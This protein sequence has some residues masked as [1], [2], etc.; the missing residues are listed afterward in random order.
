MSVE[1][2]VALEN[3]RRLVTEYSPL[4]DLS[5]EAQTRFSFVDRL[6]QE[7]LGWQNDEVKVETY[8]DGDRTDYE[9]GT[10]R[11]LII[12]AKRSSAPLKLPP[13]STRNPNRAR[14]DSIIAYS[15]VTAEAIKQ[16]QE[17]C[18]KRGVELAVLSNAQQLIIF[19]AIRTDGLAPSSGQAFVFDGYG[20]Q[21]K[22]F[23]VVFDL[24]SSDGVHEKRYQELLGG[25]AN[26]TLPTKLSSSCADYYSYNYA[27]EFQENLRNVA[28]LVIEDLG[29]SEDVE[30]EFLEDCYCESGPLSQYS[31]L[32]RN[33][34]TARYAALFSSGAAGSRVETINPRHSDPKQFSERVMAEALAKRP[35]ALIGD[36][37]VGKSS[38]LKHLIKVSASDIF[39]KAISVY[40]DLGAS[41]SLSK[42]TKDAF[43]DRVEQTIRKDLKINRLDSD[44]IEAIYKDELAEFDNGIMRELASVNNDRFLEKR[45]ELI[46]DLVDRRENHLRLTLA[47]VARR[48]ACQIV[49]VIDNADQ[50]SAAV[51]TESFVIAQELCA[52]W[53]AI[54]FIALWPQTFHRSKQSGVISAYPSKVFVIPPPK[55]EEAIDRRLGFA[56]KICE[57]RIPV[58]SLAGVSLHLESLTILIKV[59]RESLSRDRELMEF[60]VNVSGGNV[61]RAVEL[62]SRFF[63]NPN[64]QTER[65]VKKATDGDGYIIPV[66]EFARTALLGDYSHYQEGS[67]IAFNVFD[68]VYP[69][70]KEHFLALF[71][72]GYLSWDVATSNDADGFVKTPAIVR[73]MQGLGF[74]FDQVKFH[75][76][77]LARKRLAEVPERK[78]LESDE[79]LRSGLPESFR[80]TSLG[81]YTLKRWAGDFSFLEAMSF[82]TPIFDSDTRTELAKQLNDNRLRARFARAEGFRDYL[83]ATWRLLSAKPYF[84]WESIVAV[85]AGSFARVMRRL[86]DLGYLPERKAE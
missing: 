40:F 64:I 69:D 21:I 85:G 50:R 67:S 7:C 81:A 39:K 61:R 49:I 19:L 9:C 45:L 4:G 82:D 38:F 42:S 53:N 58:Q 71:L 60:L 43:L 8:E 65:I 31:L 83:G 25:G 59:L 15:D 17:Y 74:T 73:E 12:E 48:R 2:S 22:S 30:R 76:I 29:R 32:G 33:I 70:S 23:S 14:L 3:L 56:Q 66:H 55:L 13:K 28:S 51:Q 18:Q 27:S 36:V 41:A 72:L 54:V 20:E 62:I 10:P 35:L 11:S 5:N 47:Y 75:L 86:T 1:Y 80:I 57:G 37:G 63:G 84:D 16:V 24:L 78:T 68:V 6:L 77:R 46:S 79:D 44:L 34:L 52:T 26:T